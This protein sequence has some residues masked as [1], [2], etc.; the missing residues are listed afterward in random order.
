MLFRQSALS[1]LARDTIVEEAGHMPDD[2]YPAFIGS[3]EIG[4]GL[5]ATGL[6]GLNAR[7][8]QYRDTFSLMYDRT[9]VQDDLYIRRD[10]AVSKHEVLNT[11]LWNPSTNFLLMPCGW[12]DYT[13]EIDKQV[14]DTARLVAEATEWRREFSPI[15]GIVKTSFRIGETRITWQ[16]GVA[17]DSVEL[18]LLLEIVHLDARPRPVRVTVRCRQT[19]RAG[20]ALATGGVETLYTVNF[21]YRSWQASTATSTAPVLDPIHVSWALGAHGD[22]TYSAPP[23]WIA[24]TLTTKKI[25]FEGGF[26]LVTGSDRNNTHSRAHAEERLAEFRAHPVTDALAATAATWREFLNRGAELWIG[27][28]MKEFLVLQGQYLMRAGAGWRNGVPM[29]TLF[30][31]GITPATYWDSFFTADGML[32]CGHIQEV[33]ALCQWLTQTMAPKGRPHYWMTY[34]NGVPIETTDQA[35]QVVLS[36]AG[37]FI[38]LCECT[39]DADDLRRL[40]YPYLWR[41]SQYALDEVLQQDASGWHLKGEVAHDVDTGAQVASQQPGML[42]WVIVCL[43]K[44]AQYAAQ[45][46]KDDPVV[47]RCREVDAHFR[48]HPID[49]THPGMWDLWLPLLTGADPLADF[50]SWSR[51]ALETLPKT[52][53][54]FYAIQPWWNFAVATSLSQT[55]HPDLALE[56]QN[57]GLNSISGLGNIDE[58]AYEAHGGGWAPFPT[59]TGPWLSSMMIGFADGSLWND[60]LLVC[61]RL[62]KRLAN[63]YLRWRGVTTFNGGHVSGAYDPHRIEATI[64][65]AVPR[66]VRVKIPARIAGEPLT[67]RLDES[68]VAF[69][70]DGE[71]VLIQMPAGEHTIFITRDLAAPAEI[72]VAEPMNQGQLLVDLLR[73]KDH[74]IRWARDYDALPAAGRQARALVMDVSYVATPVDIAR[75]LEA[76]VRENGLSLITLFHAGCV[77][78]DGALAELSGVRATFDGTEREYWQTGATEH[79]WQLTDAGRRLLPGINVTLHVPCAGKFAPHLAKDV[80]VL[81]TDETGRAVMTCRAVGRGK[82]YWIAFGSR[83]MNF[84]SIDKLHYAA[85]NLWTLGRDIQ[86]DADLLWLKNEDSRGLLRAVVASTVNA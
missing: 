35:Y 32:R 47:A 17:L 2:I 39:R 41:V 27:D 76:A 10:S 13:I 7:T 5:D 15:T 74:T 22:A 52:P 83:V 24:V 69:Q 67:V 82:V 86:D 42:L 11:P 38:R 63:Q 31:Q 59:S 8:R 57:D 1:S 79:T 64:E 30:T 4:L 65:S 72:V 85:K 12:L 14:Y 81:A 55:D 6:Q 50:G 21:A 19:T 62:P 48:T 71:T 51:M 68:P 75:G 49:L 28:P 45:L 3:G 54:N 33:R 25:R 53:M 26:R 37:I 43:S 46:G 23:E 78:V 80:E 18:D 60:E 56:I 20:T 16:A 66:P 77:N 29:S 36:F 73:T 9:A 58:V 61:T 34:H 40:A 84:G 44:C 70:E